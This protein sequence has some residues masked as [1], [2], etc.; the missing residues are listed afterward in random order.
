MAAKSKASTSVTVAERLDALANLQKIDSEID[1][2]IT[3]RGELPLE[4]QD[5]E[6]DIQGLETRVN[7][8]QQEVEDIN[9]EIN[10][11]KNAQKDS[12]TAIIAYKEKQNNV[13][14]NREFESLSKEIEF[15]ELEIQLHDKKLK[16]AAYR[17]EK[18]NELLEETKEKIERYKEQ[19]EIKKGE[20]DKIIAETQKDEEKLLKESEKAKKKIDEHLLAAYERLRS[21]ARNGLAVVPIDRDACGGCFNRI[22]PQRQLDIMQGK[23]IIVCEHCGR[24]LIP[25]EV[26]HED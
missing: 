24:I 11:R 25:S 23:K 16:E 26:E 22:P 9:E 7:K 8:L 14:N 12:Q 15:Q 17:I 10:D 18:K 5:L 1:R 4:V 19:F 2:I 3:V 21:N 6:D 13:R 20:L